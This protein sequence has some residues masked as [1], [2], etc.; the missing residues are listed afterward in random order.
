MDDSKAARYQAIALHAL[1]ALSEGDTRPKTLH[2]LRI[3][4]RRLQAHL[5]LL[6]EDQNAEVMSD[7]VSCLSAL[8]TLQVFERYLQKLGRVDSDMRQIKKQ[9]RKLRKTLRRKHVYEKIGGRVNRHALPPI[10]ASHDWLAHRMRELRERNAQDLRALIASA[11][12]KPRRKRLHRLRLKIKSIRYQEEWALDQ[13]YAR[14]QIVAGLKQ[15]QSILG[16]YEE[17]AEFRR[18]AKELDLK[19]SGRINKD[20]RRARKRA[21]KLPFE[22]SEVVEGLAGSHIRLVRKHSAHH[23]A[24][25]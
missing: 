25:G 23:R 4:L 19:S 2:R 5:Q 3:H 14:P 24:A 20:R 13:P 18:L 12:A 15:A 22:L 21:R 11:Q 8:R 9:I 16:D 17:L 10:P 1:T 7:C 6:G